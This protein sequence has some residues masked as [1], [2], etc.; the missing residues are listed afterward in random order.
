MARPSRN[1]GSRRCRA[2]AEAARDRPRQTA[3][4]RA[5]PEGPA[6]DRPAGL[7]ERERG[8]ELHGAGSGQRADGR[9]R[10]GAG[11]GSGVERSG[12]RRGPHG[13]AEG[14]RAA[15]SRDGR[16]RVRAG[17]PVARSEV[18]RSPGQLRGPTL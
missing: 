1:S 5:K 11:E 12:A 2:R 10:S 17:G 3:G 4:A 9:E 15:L 8:R 7:G 13:G 6:A 14:R 16:N 18:A